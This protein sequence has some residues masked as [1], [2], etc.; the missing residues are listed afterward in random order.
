MFNLREVVIE[1]TFK[2]SKGE[3]TQVV[4]APREPNELVQMGAILAATC[5]NHKRHDMLVVHS[6]RV[7]I[8]QVN[9][10]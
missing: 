10:S 3:L 4:V 1:A 9:S 6:I 5:N 8:T 2:R 7:L